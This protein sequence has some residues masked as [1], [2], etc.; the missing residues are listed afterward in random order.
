MDAPSR[1]GSRLAFLAFFC[2]LF[3]FF[4]PFEQG[5]PKPSMLPKYVIAGA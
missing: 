1:L 4:T 5:G 3:L 2:T